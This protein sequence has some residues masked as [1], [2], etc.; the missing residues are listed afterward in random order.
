MNEPKV[1]TQLNNQWVEIDGLLDATTKYLA[2]GVTLNA[3]PTFINNGTGSIQV[4][5]PIGTPLVI[6]AAGATTSALT[7]VA[8]TNGDYRALITSVFN[9]AVGTGYKIV[10]DVTAPGGFVGHWELDAVVK[11]RKS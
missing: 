3:T 2:D 6:G 5:G 4:F 9:P 11:V 7:Y 10:V 8:G 1:L